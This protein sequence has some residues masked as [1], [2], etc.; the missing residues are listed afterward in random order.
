MTTGG[1]GGRAGGRSDCLVDHLVRARGLGT[2]R[3]A[4]VYYNGVGGCC[5][6]GVGDG[7]TW[8]SGVGDRINVQS[9]STG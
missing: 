3:G 2:K 1:G 9:I 8:A 4:A 6:A 7:G 5:G